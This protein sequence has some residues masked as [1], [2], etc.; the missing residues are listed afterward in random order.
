MFV[1][2]LEFPK[3]LSIF[4]LASFPF[5]LAAA[6][7]TVVYDPSSVSGGPFPSNVLTV[8][9]SS[10]STGLR[11]NLPAGNDCTMTG[12]PSVCSNSA[13]LDQLDGFSVN[14]RVMVC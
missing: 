12:D 13:L 2:S 7:T 11:V 5:C 9:D 3:I 14:P 10:E 4:V 8:A 1:K 6:P